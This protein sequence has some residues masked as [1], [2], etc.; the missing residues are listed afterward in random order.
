MYSINVPPYDNTT[1]TINSIN[2]P[3]Y[4]NTTITINNT[5][6]IIDAIHV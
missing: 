2:V 5:S 3:P 6:S 1:S 4:D